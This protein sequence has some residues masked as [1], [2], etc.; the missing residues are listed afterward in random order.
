MTESKADFGL[1]DRA[2]HLFQQMRE[3]AAGLRVA[4]SRGSSGEHLMDAGAA[5]PGGIEAGL[6][7]AKICMGGMGHA[8]IVS[9]ATIPRWPWTITV[10]SS[11]PVIACLGSQYAGWRLSHGEGRDG[12]FALGSGPARAAAR[13]EDLFNELGYGE[14][15]SHA[16]LVL[17]SPRPPPGP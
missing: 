6:R 2:W 10:A 16:V 15:A 13:R 7:I 14:A 3:D 1:N 9:N 17:E 4:I 5:T 11:L 12:F 8:R